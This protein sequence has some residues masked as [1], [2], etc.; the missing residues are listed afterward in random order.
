MIIVM[1]VLGLCDFLSIIVVL[2]YILL[3]I[4]DIT[5]NILMY[6]IRYILAVNK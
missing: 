3:L 6:S 4:I 1:K 2:I 5:I